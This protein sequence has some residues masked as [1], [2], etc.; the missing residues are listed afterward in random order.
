[1]PLAIQRYTLQRTRDDDDNTPRS[2]RQALAAGSS[3]KPFRPMRMKFNILN[4]ILTF[5]SG[6]ILL[7]NPDKERRYCKRSL[8]SRNCDQRSKPNAANKN[9]LAPGGG[10][11]IN[12]G[13]GK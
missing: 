11:A 9:I 13:G 10:G 2:F 8:T 4:F 3:I 7:R 1:M 6:P 12:E 5:P